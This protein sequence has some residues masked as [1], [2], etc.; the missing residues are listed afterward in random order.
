MP[1]RRPS[2]ASVSAVIGGAVLACLLLGGHIFPSTSRKGVYDSATYTGKTVK[3]ATWN[4]AAINNNPFE[5][6]ISD[7]GPEYEALVSGFSKVVEAPTAQQ[8][9]MVQEIFTAEMEEELFAM[10]KA[11]GWKKVDVVRQRYRDDIAKRT[12]ISDFLLDKVIG[13]KRLISMFD[14]V[15]NTISLST[16]ETVYRPSA[17]NCYEGSLKKVKVWWKEWLGFVFLNKMPLPGRRGQPATTK[18]VRDTLVPITRAKY[19]AISEEE[20]LASIPLQTLHGAIFDTIVTYIL[21]TLDP[22]WETI[23]S[24]MCSALNRGKVKRTVQILEQTYADSDVIFLQEVGPSLVKNLRELSLFR[25]RFT[26]IT[27]ERFDNDRSQNSVMLLRDDVWGGHEEVTHTVL[28]SG[29]AKRVGGVSPGD[30]LAVSVTHKPTGET[31]LLASFHGD[32]DGLMTIP[33]TEAVHAAAGHRK[34]IFGLDANTHE[35]GDVSKQGVSEF[36][37]FFVAKDLSS[38]WGMWLAFFFK[39][40]ERETVASERLLYRL[41]KRLQIDYEKCR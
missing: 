1:F 15:T 12:I 36:G 29:D 4:V 32:T 37:A 17:V 23:R 24:K 35:R 8:N 30:L 5:Y 40:G 14:R 18:L 11:A 27:P 13:K 6:W 38:S 22:S 7:G 34:I 41:S 2:L 33:V 19:P 10:M 31:Y 39:G 25:N 3:A 21:N 16:G 28:S 26:L 20:S 9:L